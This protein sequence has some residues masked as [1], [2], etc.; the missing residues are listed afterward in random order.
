LV[1]E[2]QLL[3]SSDVQLQ[4]IRK[5]RDHLGEKYDK[6]GA[7]WA[8][9]SGWLR[10]WWRS[11]LSIRPRRTPR[12]LMCAEAQLVCL[13]AAGI[14][15]VAECYEETTDPETLL[16]KLEGSDQVLKVFPR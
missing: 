9:I 1:A 15:D 14:R 8:G 16:E 2:F 7:L 4:A 6:I 3:V 5:M 11:K 13:K 12:K 10:R